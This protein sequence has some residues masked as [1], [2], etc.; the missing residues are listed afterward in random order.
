MA[1]HFSK[2]ISFIP[3]RIPLNMN[4]RSKNYPCPPFQLSHNIL[5]MTYV[6]ITRKYI[7]ILTL[8]DSYTLDSLCVHLALT[9]I[10]TL[11]SIP[12]FGFYCAS[13]IMYF[14]LLYLATFWDLPSE[15]F[16]FWLFYLLL[17]SGDIHPNP[18]PLVHPND[19]SSGFLSFSNWNLNSLA[20]ND[21]KRITLLHAENIIHKY[22]IISLCETSLND[23]TVVPT[24]AI[25]GYVFHPLNHP[26]GERHG[27]VG[28]FY[29][30]SLPLRVRDDLSFDECLVIELKFGRKKIF[31]S[32]LYRNPRNK[33]SSVEFHTFLSNF[34]SLYGKIQLENPYV[35]FFTGDVNGH[36]QAWYADGDTNAEGAAMNDLFNDLDLHQLINEPTHFF[37][38]I[39]NPSCIDIILTDQPNLVLSSGVRPSLDPLVKHQMTFCKLNFKIPV[40]QNMTEKYDTSKRLRLS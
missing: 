25:P 1:F 21:F 6:L 7:T 18:G 36:T 9:C 22:D 20:A 10:H 5:L 29:K 11:E 30:E 32:V 19:F 35:T 8:L 4:K 26:S 37:N 15:L 28:I 33:A 16:A 14:P 24:D 27:G 38:D 12:S 31:F 2:K 3:F 34:E 13:S 40:H 39:S 17:L 23:E